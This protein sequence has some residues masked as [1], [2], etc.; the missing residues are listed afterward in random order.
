MSKSI[1]I[2]IIGAGRIGAF[3][4]KNA[5]FFTDAKVLAVADISKN[6]AENLAKQIGAKK[7]YS[8]Y[9][10]LIKDKDIDAVI[11]LQSILILTI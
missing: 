5:A 8:S 11:I 1:N 4:A 3:H 10:D 7:V 9:I 6:A 2:G